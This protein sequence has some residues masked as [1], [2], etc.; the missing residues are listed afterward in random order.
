MKSVENKPIVIKRIKVSEIDDPYGEYECIHCLGRSCGVVFYSEMVHCHADVINLE[1]DYENDE[2]DDYN[3]REVNHYSCRLCG[4]TSSSL[5]DLF[6]SV[7][8]MNEEEEEV[9]S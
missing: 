7:Q 4:Q 2:S 1:G 6:R 9:I 5:L 3:S 8:I